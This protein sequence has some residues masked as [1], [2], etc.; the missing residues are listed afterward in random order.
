MAKQGPPDK[1]S[2]FSLALTCK[3]RSAPPNTDDDGDFEDVQHKN[4][5]QIIILSMSTL[6]RRGL[7]SN[8]IT[9]FL[10]NRK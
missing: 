6:G 4:R 1:N 8:L 9:H 2:N 5:Q 3:K 7:N 10:H